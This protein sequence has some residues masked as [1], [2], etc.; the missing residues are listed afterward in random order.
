M[1]ITHQ[2]SLIF[3]QFT[4]LD[5]GGCA[6]FKIDKYSKKMREMMILVLLYDKNSV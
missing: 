4:V 5:F 1:Y 3:L 6:Y 2:T